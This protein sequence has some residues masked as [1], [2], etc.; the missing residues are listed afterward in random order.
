M[1]SFTRF[2]GFALIMSVFVVLACDEDNGVEPPTPAL[3]INVVY[4]FTKNSNPADTVTGLQSNDVYDVM[5]DSRDRTWV[6]SNAGVS[7]YIGRTGDGVFNRNNVLPNPKCRTLF[8]HNDKLWIGTWGGGVGVYD[9]AADAWS[10]LTVDSGL[11]NGLVSDIKADGDDIYFATSNNVSIYKDDDQLPMDQ[12]WSE[13]TTDDGLLTPVV[14][15]IEIANTRTRGREIWYG[16]RMEEMILPGD[17][18]SFG[19]TV[20]REGLSLPIH[21]TTVNSGLLEPNVNDIFYDDV[22]ELFWVAFSTLGLASVDVDGSTWTYY[23]MVQGLPSDVVYS[24]TSVDGVIW[25]GTQGG[26]AR[27]LSDGRFRGYGRSGGLPGDRVR[28]VY[29]NSATVLWSGFIENGAALLDPRSAK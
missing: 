22:T 18:D 15:T 17:Y 20:E 1:K 2:I 16:P 25:V 4:A 9:I 23:S 12:R 6:A 3:Q 24:I 7:R 11:V 14:S 13:Y 10:Q 28:R 27:M 8:E 21:Y 5:V 26:V 19:I 29:S